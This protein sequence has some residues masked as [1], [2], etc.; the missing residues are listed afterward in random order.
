MEKAKG[1]HWFIELQSNLKVFQNQLRKHAADSLLTES[2]VR[3]WGWIRH[4][5]WESETGRRMYRWKDRLNLKSCLKR[6]TAGAQCAWCEMRMW[7]W[8]ADEVY[9][10]QY[11]CSLQT[12]SWRNWQESG[13]VVVAANNSLQSVW[14]KLKLD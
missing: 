13:K 12:L 6:K 5:V 14:F 4:C 10:Y 1:V 3:G 2:R 8:K 7:N 11:S 9:L